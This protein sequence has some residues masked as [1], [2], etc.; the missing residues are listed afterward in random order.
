MNVLEIRLI[1]CKL[2]AQKQLQ[3]RIVC[4]G[5]AYILLLISE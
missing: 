3:F 1:K 4:V 5:N 2:F